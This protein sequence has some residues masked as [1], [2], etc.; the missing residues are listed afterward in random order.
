[1][2]QLSRNADAITRAEHGSFNDGIHIQFPRNLW[3]GFVGLLEPHGSGSGDHTK[4]ADL[5]QTCYQSLCQTIR[6]ILLLGIA[7]EIVQGQDCQRLD[8]VGT[9]RG[10]LNK[11]VTA[12]GESFNEARAVG[13]VAEGFSQLV[14]G[15][16]QAV[17]EIDEGVGGPEFVAQLLAGNDFTGMFQ[18][19]DQ[20][21]EGLFL[22]PDLRAMLTQFTGPQIDLKRAKANALQ[23]GRRAFHEV[24]R[25]LQNLR[26]LIIP[27]QL[28]QRLGVRVDTRTRPIIRGNRL[29]DKQVISWGPTGH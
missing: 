13:G 11:A 16:V 23:P 7:G 18:K 9:D 8:A 24:V 10:T 3:E 2:N 5:S 20:D 4:R 15:L 25:S 22:E 28:P 27:L 17:I 21:L 19:H 12:L 29:R 1:M 26:K 14:D 6:E